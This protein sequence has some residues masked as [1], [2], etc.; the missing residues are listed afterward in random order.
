MKKGMYKKD[1]VWRPSTH[2]FREKSE[3]TKK[4]YYTKSYI[5]NL[6]LKYLPEPRS[7]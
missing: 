4:L 7:Q 2:F 3:Y 5:L 1:L 6:C